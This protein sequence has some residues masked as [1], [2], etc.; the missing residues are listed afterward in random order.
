M[1]DRNGRGHLVS[2]PRPRP[3]KPRSDAHAVETLGDEPFIAYALV[4]AFTLLIAL[5]RKRWPEIG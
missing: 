4:R 5:L 3:E 2:L 1:S